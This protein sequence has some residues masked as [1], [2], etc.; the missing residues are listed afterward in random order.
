MISVIIPVYNAADYI[1]ATCQCLERQTF[2]D[3]EVIFIDDGSQ[4]QSV[5]LINQFSSTLPAFQCIRQRNQ[6]ASTARN[7]GLEVASGE[8][9]VFVDVDDVFEPNYL[10]FLMSNLLLEDADVSICGH[11]I[12]VGGHLSRFDK[13]KKRCLN[14]DE[15]F[16]V[17]MRID[18]FG[19]YLWNKLFRR[20]V[21]KDIRFDDEINMMED[22]LFCTEVFANCETII[23]EPVILYHYIKRKGSITSMKFSNVTI[24]SMDALEKMLKLVE[25]RDV[26]LKRFNRFYATTNVNHLMQGYHN[27]LLTDDLKEKLMNY[28]QEHPPETSFQKMI[29]RMLE[30][31]I[32][33]VYRLWKPIY[34]LSNVLLNH[35]YD[36]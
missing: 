13:G 36:E 19:G 28:F 24:T 35:S 4:D 11:D 22:A 32:E 29:V 23:Y 7:Q 26:N 6:G 17:L 33:N 8:Y 2:R 1:E 10:E 34:K 3:F 21:I 9:I 20:E 16:D 30:G 12:A 18:A 27:N 5:A 25:G 14:P 31:N 15:A